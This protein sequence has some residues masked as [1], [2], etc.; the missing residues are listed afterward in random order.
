M[1]TRAFGPAAGALP[2]TPSPI[3]GPNEKVA[4]GARTATLL[5]VAS[6]LG[7]GI[8]TTTGFLVR[9]LGSPI[10]VLAVWAVGGLL[11]WSGA[12][13]YAELVTALP[14]NGGEYQLLGRIYHPA[15]GFAAGMVSLVVGFAAPLAASALAFG[16]YL[17]ALVPGIEPAAAGI[18]IIATFSALHAIHVRLGGR[19][20]SVMTAVQ[21]ALLLGFV[22]AGVVL[23]DPSR[24]AAGRPAL[25]AVGSPSFAISLVYFSFAY[26]G[27]NGAAY[28]A[29]EVSRPSRTLPLALLLGTAIVIVLYMGLNAVFL[30]AAPATELSGVVEVGHVAATRL[31]GSAAGRLFS[32]LIALVL[33][34][35]VGAM[36]MAGPRVYQ[37]MGTDYPALRLLAWRTRHGGPT[38]AVALQA[39]I[40]TS[41]ILTSSF[42]ALLTY[43][44]FTLSLVAGVTVL[45]LFVSRWREPRLPRPYLAWGYPITP[46]LFVLLAGWMAFHAL[47]ERPAASWAGLGTILGALAL[48]GLLGWRRPLPDAALP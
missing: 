44:G 10:A 14:R 3:S 45:G 48:H 23:G 38:V 18:A 34:S 4:I 8:F 19:F 40:A 20:Q 43:V 27:W 15:L 22:V 5:V 1:S 39:L 36:I 30:A 24:L 9:D 47:A 35:S 37:A 12:L 28:L 6:M 2:V 32:G 7:T 26:S 29:G 46:A 16:H 11:A 41:M 13:S 33:A 42:S 21:V 31:F 25:E 17:S